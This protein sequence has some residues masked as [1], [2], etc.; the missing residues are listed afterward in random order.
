MAAK[1]QFG[2]PGA[3]GARRRLAHNRS[4]H[5]ERQTTER[6]ESRR[7]RSTL[8]VQTVFLRACQCTVEPPVGPIVGVRDGASLA[9]NDSSD[10]FPTTSTLAVAVRFRSPCT[11]RA[12]RMES[13]PRMAAT[14]RHPSEKPTSTAL[15]PQLISACGIPRM[16]SRPQPNQS[17]T[18][19]R[20]SQA[21]LDHSVRVA[22][23]R[24]EGR[25][26][27]P[28]W[29]SCRYGRAN[30]ASLH[31]TARETR[32]RLT[33]VERIPYTGCRHVNARWVLPQLPT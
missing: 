26:R 32:S 5:A 10:E 22:A 16:R 31:V 6:P 12:G 27:A 17:A 4:E 21:K 30:D 8:H 13:R 20:K 24:S 11:T 7:L 23:R 33:S 14:T 29:E 9:G 15:R 19:R 28:D 2:E 3:G 1:S 18:Y 25:G